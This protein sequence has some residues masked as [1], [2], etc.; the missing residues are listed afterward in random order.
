MLSKKICYAK[1][2]STL[3]EGLTT[4]GDYLLDELFTHCGLNVENANN[5]SLEKC[6]NKISHL[7]GNNYE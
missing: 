1:A 5:Y 2:P 6:L 7:L 4:G 3:S